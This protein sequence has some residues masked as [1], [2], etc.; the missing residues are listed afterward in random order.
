LT[1]QKWDLK[2]RAESGST[3]AP[4]GFSPEI[5]SLHAL[6][7]KRKRQRKS[8]IHYWDLLQT[9]KITTQADR[10]QQSDGAAQN[11]L[12]KKGLAKLYGQ[13]F[14]YTVKERDK[15]ENLLRALTR[16]TCNWNQRRKQNKDENQDGSFHGN[17]RFWRQKN[18]KLNERLPDLRDK[19]IEHEHHKIRSKTDFSLRTNK[20]TTDPR[21]LPPS[22]LIWL[23]KWKSSVF[24][25][26]SKLVNAKWKWR[27]GKEPHSL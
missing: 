13:E 22:P 18:N 20:S 15:W 25:T 23:L 27:K 17:Y 10:N 2:S 5:G 14:S 4:T 19:S 26:L 3:S 11:E 16:T 1:S 21:R 9:K 7:A 6:A 8:P 12:E 24:G